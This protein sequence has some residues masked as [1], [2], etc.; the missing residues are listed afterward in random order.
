MRQQRQKRVRRRPDGNGSW[1]LSRGDGLN[2]RKRSASCVFCIVYSCH[3]SNRVYLAPGLALP[4]F[5]STAKQQ[6]GSSPMSQHV[7]TEADAYSATS[8]SITLQAA[9]FSVV[10]AASGHALLRMISDPSAF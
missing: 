6:R 7:L 8:P 4:A 2:K 1:L 3:V 5:A 9:L 10:R